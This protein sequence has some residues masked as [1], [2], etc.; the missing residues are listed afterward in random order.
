MKVSV[1][2]TA[3]KHEKT[4]Q[5]AIDGVLMQLDVEVDHIVIDDTH[6]NN[7][8]ME[9]FREALSRCSGEYIAFSDGDDYYIEEEKLINQVCYMIN[10]PDCGVCTTKVYTEI[11]GVRHGMTKSTDEINKNM[12]FDTLLRGQAY[13]FAQSILIRKSEFDRYIDFDKFMKFNVWDYPTI[14]TLIR[15]TRIHC[16]DFY[17]AV[18]TKNTESVTNTRKRS[19]RLKYILGNHKIKWHFILKYGCKLSTILYLIYKFARDIYSVIFLRW[20]K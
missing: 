20:N 15:H 14:L 12:S 18:Y 1:I 9:T 13:I 8:M 2:T 7:G 6:T 19:R 10:N 11:D 16:M 5:R 3:Y 17:S 4:L